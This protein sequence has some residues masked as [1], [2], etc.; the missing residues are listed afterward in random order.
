[1]PNLD[2]NVVP[3]ASSYNKPEAPDPKPELSAE[4]IRSRLNNVYEFMNKYQPQILQGMTQAQQDEDNRIARTKNNNAQY[5][6]PIYKIQNEISGNYITGPNPSLKYNNIPTLDYVNTLIEKSKIESTALADPYARMRPTAFNKTADGFNFDRYYSHDK[7][8]ELGFSI[9]RDNERIYNANS[10]AWDDFGRMGKKW[11]QLA[12]LGAAGLFRN[13]GK[14]GSAGEA[15]DAATMQELLSEATSTRGG[16]GAWFTNFAANSAYTIGILGEIAAEEFVLGTA[17]GITFGGMSPALAARSAIN[18]SRFA[19]SMKTMTQ[20]LTKADK[21][22]SFWTAARG[23]GAIGTVNSLVKGT[24]NFLNPLEHTSKLVGMAL[25]TDHAF[26]RLNEFAKISKTFGAFYKD[27]RAINA[28]TAE[29]RLEAG[30]VQN[31]VVKEAMDAFYKEKGRGPEGQEALK[32]SE[33]G[34]AAG[35]TAYLANAPAIMLSNKLVFGT[36]MKGFAPIRRMMSKEGLKSSLFKIVNNPNWKKLGTK[37]FEVLERGLFP[38]LKRTFSKQYLTSIP[39]RLSGTFS[40]RGLSSGFGS[41]LTYFSANLAEGLQ[42]SYQEAVQIATTDYYLNQYYADL[43]NDPFLAAKNTIGASIAKGIEEQFTMQGLDVFAQG[44][45]MG[46]FTS[47]LGN[48]IMPAFQRASMA[49]KSLFDNNATAYEEYVKTEKERLQKVADAR[50]S[51][52]EESGRYINWIDENVKMQRDLAGRYSDAVQSGNREEAETVKDEALLNHTLTLLQTG[53]YDSFILHMEDMLELSDEDLNDAFPTETNDQ[54]TKTNREK[55]LTAI[56]KAKNIKSRYDLI[57]E[58]VENPFNPD[59]FNKNK[60]PEAYERELRGYYTFEKAK[61]AAVVYEYTFD[62]TLKRLNSLA[63]NITSNPILGAS[64]ALDVA[65]IFMDSSF[66]GELNKNYV[67]TL[68]AEIDVLSNGTKEEKTLAKKKKTQLDNL[69]TL[70]ALTLQHRALLNLIDNAKDAFNNPETA[71][72]ES[73]EALEQLKDLAKKIAPELEIAGDPT[74][75]PITGQMSMN[76]ED[77]DI[78]NP[79]VIVTEH[80]KELLYESYAKYLKNVADLRNVFPIANGIEN[81]FGDFIDFISLE[82]RA[83]KMAD[84]ITILNDPMSILQMAS[85]IDKALEG[86]KGQRKKM[87]DDAFLEYKNK[88][89]LDELLQKLAD[90]NVYFDPNK[91]AK[92]VKDGTLPDYFINATTGEIIDEASPEYA[93][94]VDL[95]KEEEIRRG[96]TFNNKPVVPVKPENKTPAATPPV[97]SQVPPPDDLAED[98]TV[99]FD[100]TTPI[101]KLT[102]PIQNKLRELHQKAVT[103]G[104]NTDIQAWMLESPEAASVIAGTYV[105]PVNPEEQ[106]TGDGKKGKEDKDGKGTSEELT[107]RGEPKITPENP[108]SIVTPTEGTKEIY[109]QDNSNKWELTPDQSKYTNESK[110]EEVKRVSDL[111]ESTIDSENP[112]VKAAQNRGNFIDNLIRIFATPVA[113]LGG[114]SMK[115]A[116]INAFNNNKSKNE[117]LALLEDYIQGRVESEK[118]DEKHSIKVDPGFYSDMAKVLDELALRYRGYTWHPS[119]PTMVGTIMNEKYGGT[120]DLLL[121]LN[122]KYY[123]VDLKTSAKIRAGKEM[124]VEGDKLQQNAYAELFEQITGKSISGIFTLNLI[125]KVASDNKTIQNA[126]LILRKNAE[127]KESILTPVDR[128]SVAEQKGQKPP[129]APAPTDVITDQD[130]NNF[131]DN[132]VVSDVILNSIADKVINRASLSQRETAIFS[133]KTSEINEIIRNKATAPSAPTTDAKAD[134]ERRKRQSLSEKEWST[135]PVIGAYLRQESDGRWSSMYFKPSTTGIDGEGI[136]GNTKEEV[137]AELEKRYNA[138][139]AALEGKTPTSPNFNVTQ[140]MASIE[141]SLEFLHEKLDQLKMQSELNDD[142]YSNP[143]LY[144]ADNLPRITPESAR[145][146]TGVNVGSKQDIN[147]SLL[148]KNGVSVQKAAELIAANSRTEGLDLDESFIRDEIIEILKQGKNNY[149]ENNGKIN[150]KDIEAVEYEIKVLMDEYEELKKLSSSPSNNKAKAP[151]RFA[152][153]LIWAQ[154]GTIDPKVFEDYDVIY[155]N[156]IVDQVAKKMGVTPEKGK[157]IHQTIE[158]RADKN[159]ILNAIKAEVNRLKKEGKTI[160]S[161]NWY[162]KQNADV[163]SSPAAS[164]ALFMRDATGIQ[165]SVNKFKKYISDNELR[166][167]EYSKTQQ[168]DWVSKVGRGKESVEKQTNLTV[169]ELFEKGTKESTFVEDITEF[170]EKIDYL[171]DILAMYLANPEIRKMY[172]ET[173]VDGTKRILSPEE[174]LDLVKQRAKSI[175]EY[176]GELEQVNKEIEDMYNKAFPK[177]DSQISSQDKSSAQDAINEASNSANTSAASASDIASAAESKTQKEVDDEFDDSLGCK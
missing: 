72:E 123:I 113:E 27:A 94:I 71:N 42:E 143:Y 59:L 31:Q 127:G 157:S 148:S 129:A 159:E 134:I 51:Y 166:E 60:D 37:P 49:S 152:G 137:V 177:T 25:K 128:Q 39:S 8:D 17:T 149:K 103:E 155:A 54:N 160:I 73:K 135:G 153:K 1:M 109:N 125:S 67:Q 57:N 5:V 55:L 69:E 168:K 12:G 86:L 10:S 175:I 87:H 106:K 90:I 2:P 13:W 147:P 40:K 85:R 114:I 141:E 82:H 154:V 165:D 111:K 89:D 32:I 21:A 47:S 22:K 74:V 9:Y 62:R 45:L 99:E 66:F 146:E 108:K 58:K 3:F 81:S 119:L 15:E 145:K 130:Y 162:L 78:V 172:T 84:H 7:F 43:Y 126:E 48:I 64:S 63:N 170:S 151:S 50:N 140:R 61:Q 88:V 120:I 105:E 65:A 115:D 107:A 110:T 19:K 46:G 132:N 156:D 38:S 35:Q 139:L 26:H 83:K 101:N 116:V 28:V 97:S 20:L 124:Y 136:Y 144:I 96:V 75:D 118:L 102:A 18:A 70:R 79:D 174:V 95:I 6:S 112:A 92:F 164:K 68:Q 24:V 14:F 122:G 53:G 4:S 91:I 142:P 176:T 93:K 23:A 167:Q 138:E 30:F 33:K 41:G 56:D 171:K 131:V 163:I 158:S 80:S 169:R 173:N 100:V 11:F 77:T 44:F 117:R 34:F 133:G 36:Y 121:E 52:I 76:F 98:E 104:A 29:S 161:D 16:K 150:K